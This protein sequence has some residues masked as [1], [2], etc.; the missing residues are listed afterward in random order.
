MLG[1]R[2]ENGVTQV[3]LN[4]QPWIDEFGAGAILLFLKRYGD[5]VAYPVLLQTADGVA[6]WTVS[7]LDTAVNGE[8]KAEYVF[9]VGDKREKSAVFSTF[10]APDLGCAPGDPPDPYQTWVDDLT[11]LGAE[12]LQNA[13]DAAQSAE[14]AGEHAE[15]A[16]TAKNA[17]QA[18]KAEAEGARE[19]AGQSA[20]TATAAAT[21]ADES[22]QA[23][24][25]WAVGER[26]GEPVAPGDPTYNNSSKHWADVAQQGAE[27]SGF[28]WFDVDDETGQMVVTVTPNLAESVTF[29]VDENTGIL[30]VVVNG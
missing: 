23:A 5:A 24:K 21:A 25:A 26:G 29:T 14:K 3:R 2:R 11:E 20:Q 1:Q 4:Y 28:A 13:Q 16:E 12:T 6:V 22:A 8:G 27:E 7:E 9:M 19:A 10:T 15:A 30:E 17:A 18:A